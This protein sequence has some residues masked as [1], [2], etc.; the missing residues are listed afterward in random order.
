M[1]TLKKYKINGEFRPY[2]MVTAPI[3]RTTIAISGKLR[4]APRFLWR[5]P[6]LNVRELSIPGYEDTPITAYMISPVSLDA[7]APCI[8]NFHGGGFVLEGL[9]YQYRL[10]MEYA[11]KAEC[12]VLFVCYRLAPK[13]PYPYPTEDCYCALSWV[14]QNAN[15]MGIDVTRIGL[16][17]DSAGGT[18]SAAV[19]HMVRDRALPVKLSFQLL[20]YPF[21][22]VRMDSESAKKYTDVPIWNSKKSVKVQPMILQQE[23][24]ENIGYVSPVEAEDFSSLPPAYIETAEFD[25]LHDDGILYAQLLKNAGI[26]VKLIETKGTMHAFDIAT[27]APTTQMMVKKRVAFIKEMFKR[28]EQHTEN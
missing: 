28:S 4:K 13:Y 19:C 17:G 20:I 24:T 27:N 10:A 15:T 1:Y 14:L 22:D 16:C 23:I 6:E 7:P 12:N 18:L 11:K 25:S 3:N 2:S 8:L 9:P 26:T 21:L 5:D